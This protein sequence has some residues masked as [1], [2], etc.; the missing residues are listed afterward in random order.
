MTHVGVQEH[1]DAVD[2][3]DQ[4]DVARVVDDE[5]PDRLDQRERRAARRRGLLREPLAVVAGAL[6]DDRAGRG[7][8]FGPAHERRQAD[9]ARDATRPASPSSSQRGIV[10]GQPQPDRDRGDERERLQLVHQ[11][12]EVRAHRRRGALEAG[13]LA[14]GAVEHVRKLDDGG[15]RDERAPARQ[16]RQHG[17]ARQEHG[18]RRKRHLVG[19]DAGAR[20]RHDQHGGQRPGD[21][22]VPDDVVRLPRAAVDVCG[23]AQHAQ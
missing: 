21:Q 6:A 18:Q 5:A 3:R 7:G 20:E 9:R 4:P 8:V 17:R 10:R 15:A 23:R 16:Q 13:Q 11:E 19:R 1:V 12:V 14:V 22:P 2:Q